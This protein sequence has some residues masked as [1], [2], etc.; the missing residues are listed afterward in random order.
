MA[1]VLVPQPAVTTRDRLL[2]AAIQVFSRAGYVGATT[3]EIAREAGVSEVTLF[4]HFQRK[5]QLLKAVAQHIDQSKGSI[6]TELG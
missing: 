4:R 6:T 3:R 1:S 5:E 2:Q